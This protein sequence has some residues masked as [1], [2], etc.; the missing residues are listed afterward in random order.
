[1]RKNINEHYDK[2]YYDG[3]HYIAWRAGLVAQAI[4]DAFNPSSVIDVGCAIGDI[5]AALAAAGVQVTGIDAA[6]EAERQYAGP[7]GTFYKHDLRYQLS[8]HNRCDLCICFDTLV[9]VEPQYQKVFMRNLMSMSDN[10]LIGVPFDNEEMRTLVIRYFESKG[11]TLSPCGKFK[12]ALE[13][14]KN[15]QAVKGIYYNTLYFRKM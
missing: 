12:Q 8:I 11:Y 4:V 15:K 10:I 5:T 1:M 13:D 9:V 2:K 14:I 3:R 6:D 7:Q